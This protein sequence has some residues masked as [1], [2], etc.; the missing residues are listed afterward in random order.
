VRWR[1]R[2]VLAA[3]LALAAS[4]CSRLTFV[5]PDASRRGAEKV[6]PDYRIRDNEAA[7][8][9]TEARRQITLAD[10]HLSAGDLAE[11]ERAAQAALK[12]DRE[13]AEAHTM[14]ALVAAEQGRYELAGTHHA[15]AARLAPSGMT[16]N[17][18]GAWLCANGRAAESLEWFDQAV[19]DP[20]YGDRAGALANAGACAARAG[21]HDRVERDLRAALELDPENVVA[22]AAMAEES[23]RQ[24]RYLEAR[25]FSERRLAAGPATA[26][27]L[28]LASRIE[29]KLG[30]SVAARRYVER[31]RTEFP[32]ALNA[33]PGGSSTP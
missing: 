14:M 9:R 27:A 16:Y 5:K 21:Q 30:D 18:Y 7:K 3:A 17:N 22:L 24:G 20:R 26:A 29:D 1:E 4:G 25:A 6:A 32:Q 12:A 23:M 2:L 15:E 11:A 33:S 19:L 13:L 28:E 31:L 8:R 10:R